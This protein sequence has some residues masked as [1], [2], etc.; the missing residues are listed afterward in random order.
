ME[1]RLRAKMQLVKIDSRLGWNDLQPKTDDL[2]FPF[3]MAAVHA[4]T[5]AAWIAFKRKMNG[6]DLGS[7]PLSYFIRSIR[8]NDKN[9]T[10]SG[11]DEAYLEYL[12]QK[13]G[14]VVDDCVLSEASRVT[15]AQSPNFLF[16]LAR[17]SQRPI[18]APV[19]MAMLAGYDRREHILSWLIERYVP[20]N[21]DKNQ[22]ERFDD[23]IR[24]ILWADHPGEDIAWIIEDVNSR[25]HT[26]LKPCA[27]DLAKRLPRYR[28]W[29]SGLHRHL[30]NWRPSD[31]LLRQ[32]WQC[33][34]P[35]KFLSPLFQFE[36]IKRDQDCPQLQQ[37]IQWTLEEPDDKTFNFLVRQVGGTELAALLPLPPPLMVGWDP[38]F[39]QSF[40][41]RLE[42]IKR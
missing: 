26:I 30:P 14:I 5:H 20:R 21:W 12:V 19:I 1:R 4:Q 2:E 3:L 37:L 36:L 13:Q 22:P 39:G 24:G 18:P 16:H 10:R 38:F 40:E 29:L 42:E 31:D 7:R 17:I 8:T 9:R 27:P 11:D 6:R 33:H 25:R 15:R 28:D 32:L 41:W 35:D 34:E 23:V